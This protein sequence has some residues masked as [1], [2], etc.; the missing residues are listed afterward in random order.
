MSEKFPYMVQVKFDTALAAEPPMDWCYATIGK[1][2]E[3]GWT[4]SVNGYPNDVVFWFKFEKHAIM[5]ALKFS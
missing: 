2:Q 1:I 5:F 3:G 4:C